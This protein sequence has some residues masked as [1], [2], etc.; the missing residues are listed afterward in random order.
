MQQAWRP[1]AAPFGKFDIVKEASRI[2]PRCCQAP[3][4]IEFGFSSMLP[5][6]H[7]RLEG[8]K[9]RSDVIGIV[10]NDRA[11]IRLVG[12]LMLEQNN[13]WAVYIITRDTTTGSSLTA[14][15]TRDFGANRG[16]AP[17]GEKPPMVAT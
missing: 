12:A 16:P 6:D 9:R 3:C 7:A 2:N 8:V 14:C 5:N 15:I 1:A 10:P 13:E 11:V 17:E 4:A